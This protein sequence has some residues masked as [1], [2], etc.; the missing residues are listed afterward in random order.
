MDIFGELIFASLVSALCAVLAYGFLLLVHF[1]LSLPMRRRDRALLFLDVM[2]TVMNNNQSLEV[3]ILEAAASRD[4]ALGM[5]FYLLAAHIENGCRLGEALAK[6]PRFLPPPVTAMLQA[7]EKLGDLRKVLPACREVLRHPPDTV[8]ATMHYMTAT[9]IIFAPLAIWVIGWFSLKVIPWFKDIAAAM[10]QPLWPITIFTF[11]LYDS[12][13]LL[14]LESVIL[15]VLLL[16]VLVY[17]GG[18]GFVQTFRFR[19]FPLVDWIAWRTPWK[20]KQLQRTFSAM[21]AVLLD[22]GVPEGEAVRL[23][24]NATANEICRRKAGRVIVALQKGV[25]LDDAVRAFDD[26]GEFHWRLANAIHAHGGFLQALRGWHDT[27]D[28][29][30]LQQQEIAT[31]TFTSG[32]VIL[33]G[34]IVGLIATSMFGVLIAI[35]RGGLQL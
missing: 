28:A 17:I 13:V 21:L 33:N 30:A 19:M 11:E 34:I 9:L 31:Q 18:P 15:I 25:K 29:K 14:C 27:L 4:V 1:L 6:V 16:V 32:L 24:G 26:S 12:N 35:L 7:G 2:E 3:G 22:G 23:A 10:G 8:R 5:Q 20:R